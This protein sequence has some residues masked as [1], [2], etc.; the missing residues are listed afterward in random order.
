MEQIH[1]WITLPL[2]GVENLID[3]LHSSFKYLTITLAQNSN[4]LI[5]DSTPSSIYE[6]YLWVLF[7]WVC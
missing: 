7:I 6:I 4:H 3:I 1:N 2:S 5:S